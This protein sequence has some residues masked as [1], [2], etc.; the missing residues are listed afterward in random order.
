VILLFIAGHGVN[1]QDGSFYF[2]PSDTAFN[3]DGSIRSSRAISYRDI[4]SVL[5]WPG[6]KLVFID[7]CHSAGT[8]SSLIRRVNNDRLINDLNSNPS[9]R[10]SSVIFTSS[11]GDQSSLEMERYKH[12]VFTYAI[13]QGLKGEADLLKKGFITM[14]AL[15]LYIRDKIPALTDG[16]QNPTTSRPD[17]YDDFVVV[18]V[19]R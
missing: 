15:E 6:Q 11:K 18:E 19:G 5:D 1:D 7:A 8:S 17:G 12:G 14:T 13:L 10:S 9:I 3:T 4:Q 16:R 2:L